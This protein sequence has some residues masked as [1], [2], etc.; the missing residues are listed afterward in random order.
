MDLERIESLLKLMQDYRVAELGLDADDGSIH[1]SLMHDGAQ[2]AA[3]PQIVQVAATSVAS[4]SEAAPASASDNFHDMKSPMVGTFYPAPKPGSPAFVKVGDVIS[5]G[6]VLC[7]V[8]AMKLMN[9]IES[10]VSGTVRE[11]AL[12]NGDPVQ[13]GQVLFRIEPN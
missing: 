12:G 6:Q 10:E 11:I 8:E 1:I 7:I 4:A 5:V 13:F 2:V 9:E 3:A